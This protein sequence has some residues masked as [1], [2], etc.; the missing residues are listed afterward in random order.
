[1]NKKCLKFET[2]SAYVINT[3]ISL[4]NLYV[5]CVGLGFICKYIFLLWL[6]KLI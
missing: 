1:M 6:D 4:L 3:L 2:E 5:W